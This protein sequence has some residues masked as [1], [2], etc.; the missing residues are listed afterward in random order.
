MYYLIIQNKIMQK[1][2]LL[3]KRIYLNIEITEKE[4]FVQN[5]KGESKKR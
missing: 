3:T 5:E 4:V 2:K 1:E